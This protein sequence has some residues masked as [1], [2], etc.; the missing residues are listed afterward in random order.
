MDLNNTVRSKHIAEEKFEK[1][2]LGWQSEA[3]LVEN[4]LRWV[5]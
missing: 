2:I 1:F 3:V 4:L 5:E